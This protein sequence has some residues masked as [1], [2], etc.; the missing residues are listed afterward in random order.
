MK[1]NRQKINNS[2]NM[3]LGE[4]HGEKLVVLGV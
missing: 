2:Q 4:C 1:E 3:Q